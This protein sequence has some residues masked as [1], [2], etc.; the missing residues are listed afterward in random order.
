MITFDLSGLDSVMDGMN[1]KPKRKPR[2]KKK[3]HPKEVL[4]RADGKTLVIYDPK[5]KDSDKN[6]YIYEKVVLATKRL[7][8]DE[9][10]PRLIVESDVDGAHY[11][12]YNDD[13]VSFGGFLSKIEKA[14]EAKPG[15]EFSGWKR[16]KQYRF[17]ET[18]ISDMI[19]DKVFEPNL[20]ALFGAFGF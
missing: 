2:P 1:E 14:E 8:G 10:N 4:D 6:G 17:T 5:R 12:L 18:E 15:T 7:K 13:T 11:V 9:L 20:R 16:S 3:S 19:K